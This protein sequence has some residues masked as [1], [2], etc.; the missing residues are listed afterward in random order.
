MAFAYVGGDTDSQG[1]NTTSLSPTLPTHAAG[2]HGFLYARSDDGTPSPA[3][4]LTVAT[5]WTLIAYQNPTTGRDRHEYYWYK[6]FTSS[7][8]TA[9]VITIDQ[10]EPHSLC[11]DVFSGGDDATILDVTPVFASDAN[12]ALPTNSAITTVT[13]NCAILLYHG[14]THNDISVAGAPSGY[15]LGQSLTPGSSY[16]HRQLFSAYLLDAGSLGT[17]TPGVWTHT[18]SPR[19]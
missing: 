13:D 2:Q 4:A 16:N 6:K 14:A 7:S 17:K 10:S 12:N 8:E 5:G 15:T 11:L 18:A 1:A 9:P 19:S 3:M